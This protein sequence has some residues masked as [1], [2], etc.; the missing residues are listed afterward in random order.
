M[1]PKEP[2]MC[3]EY[4]K[5]AACRLRSGC[6]RRERTLSLGRVACSIKV[7]CCLHPQ[8]LILFSILSEEK[9]SKVKKTTSSPQSN[10][11]IDQSALP[12]L[13]CNSQ[14][15][16]TRGLGWPVFLERGLLFRCET[17]SWFELNKNKLKTFFLD[18][19]YKFRW[20]GVSTQVAVVC[21]IFL[22]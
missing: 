8:E 2:E 19:K 15:S 6:L 22:R 7:A 9:N 3:N 17:L 20:A 5:S 10:L 13:V 16:L 11:S 4:V 1:H 18:K 21:Q 12:L 14:S